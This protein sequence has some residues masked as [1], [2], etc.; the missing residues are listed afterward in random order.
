MVFQRPARP[1]LPGGRRR[2]PAGAHPHHRGRLLLLL[3]GRQET[4]DEPDVPRVPHLE[5]LPGRPGRRHLDQHGGHHQAGEDHRQRRPGHLPDVDRR[6]DLL[7]LRPRPD[8][9][10]VR[11]RHPLEAEPQGDLLHRIRLQVPG[12]LRRR[13]RGLRERRLYLQVRR[14]EGRRTEGGHPARR[15]RRL[16][17]HRVPQRQ[18]VRERIQPLAR[19]ETRADGGPRRHLLPA[20]RERPRGEHLPVARR[21]RARGRVEPGRVPHRLDLGRLRRVPDLHRAGRQDDRSHLPDRFQGRLS[22]QPAVEPGRPEAVLLHAALGR[23][24][25]GRSGQ[26]GQPH[27]RG[28]A[29]GHPLLHPLAGRR[30]G[31]LHHRDAE[32]PQRGVPAGPEDPQELP[33]HRPL[34]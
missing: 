26:D 34:V 13:L 24:R 12:P 5:V 10:P 30:L 25:T 21:A 20:G 7:P 2:R 27:R 11:V 23:V 9:E 4:R 15:R 6:R 22:L 3:P 31:G 29:G 32:L 18:P 33:G 28:R 19:R 8:D 16:E 14:E 1:T 17:P